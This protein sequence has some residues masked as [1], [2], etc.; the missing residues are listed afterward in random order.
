MAYQPFPEELPAEFMHIT[1][2]GNTLD[3]YY[4]SQK[5]TYVPEVYAEGQHPQNLSLYT[6]LEEDVSPEGPAFEVPP[7]VS[8]GFSPLS[9][10]AIP[11]ASR[12]SA[13]PEP[14]Q[15]ALDARSSRYILIKSYTELSDEQYEAIESLGVSDLQQRDD[16]LY[17]GVYDL[18][19]LDILRRLSYLAYVD[20]YQRFFKISTLLKWGIR[21]QLARMHDDP[22]ASGP[23]TATEPH[24]DVTI[25]L[26]RDPIPNAGQIYDELVAAGIIP[27]SDER[28]TEDHIHT[29]VAPKDLSRLTWY[30]SVECISDNSDV[31][32]D[33]NQVRNILSISRA[34]IA[35]PLVHPGLDGKGQVIHVSDSGLLS[36]LRIYDQMDSAEVCVK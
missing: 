25:G 8:S 17:L 21:K 28:P 7:R 33:N 2:L 1:I 35:P 19:D 5:Q 27:P 23:A 36:P 29:S 15:L 9:H 6:S 31:Q 11:P 4:D 30:D 18:D 14:V 22:I 10:H 32:F 12:D 24:V 20:V 3:I 16:T 26:F 13:F 34:S